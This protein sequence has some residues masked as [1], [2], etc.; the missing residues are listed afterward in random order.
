MGVISENKTSGEGFFTIAVFQKHGAQV[1]F[2]E[3]TVR[4]KDLC[5][6]ECILSLSAFPICH[7]TGDLFIPLTGDLFIPAK[8]LLQLREAAATKWW[9]PLS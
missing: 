1:K 3:V 4:R 6:A 9:Y 8:W 2:S 7:F 5:V